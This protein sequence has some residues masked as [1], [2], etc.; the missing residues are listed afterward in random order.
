M[1]EKRASLA[2]VPLYLA[3][4][5]M[6]LCSECNKKLFDWRASSTTCKL[7]K[8]KNLG[9]HYQKDVAVSGACLRFRLTEQPW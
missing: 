3:T 2:V 1:P 4:A 9:N 6:F 7:T 8:R 5:E